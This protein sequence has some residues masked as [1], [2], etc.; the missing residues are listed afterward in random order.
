MLFV[1]LFDFRSGT[2]TRTTAKWR[3]CQPTEFLH[4]EFTQPTTAATTTT[5]ATMGRVSPAA[6]VETVRG[7]VHRLLVPRHPQDHHHLHGR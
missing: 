5:A 6:A 3:G 7:G 1:C 2:A 4:P